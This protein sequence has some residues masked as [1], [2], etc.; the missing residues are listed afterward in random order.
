MPQQIKLDI[1]VNI[2]ILVILIQQSDH[3]R[4]QFISYKIIN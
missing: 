2:D 3:L 4:K 1:D